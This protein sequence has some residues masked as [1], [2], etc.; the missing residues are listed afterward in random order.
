VPGTEDP[1]RYAVIGAR[2][3]VLGTVTRLIV[4][5]QTD[6]IAYLV[7]NTRIS[8]FREG[9]GEDRLVPVGWSELVGSRRQVR[10]PHLAWYAFRQLPLYLDG[11]PLPEQIEFPRPFEDEDLRDIA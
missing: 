5:T 6:Q 7:V 8:N 2:D 4:D 10:L 3:F 11:A 9:R 1:T